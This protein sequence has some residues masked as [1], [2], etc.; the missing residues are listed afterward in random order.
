M[1]WPRD[2]AAFNSQCRFSIAPAQH[3]APRE[4][5]HCGSSPTRDVAD[6][7]FRFH[8]ASRGDAAENFSRHLIASVIIFISF[9]AACCCRPDGLTISTSASRVSFITMLSGRA[10]SALERSRRGGGARSPSAPT[11]IGTPITA[12]RSSIEHARKSRHERGRLGEL[13]SPSACR[14]Y[15]RQLMMGAMAITEPSLSA[16]ISPT[17]EGPAIHRLSP[18]GHGGA[19]AR[20]YRHLLDATAHA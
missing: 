3:R 1:P 2:A 12:P 18:P 5:L 9:Q 13:I 16:A 14:V 20:V 6:S 15:R 8:P 11:V 4:M 7:R 19:P 10:A 17:R